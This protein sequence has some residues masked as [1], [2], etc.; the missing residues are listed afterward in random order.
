MT[1]SSAAPSRGEEKARRSTR[2]RHLSLFE[3]AATSAVTLGSME[4][5]VNGRP[6]EAVRGGVTSVRLTSSD[7]GSVR[8]DHYFSRH[9]HGNN[10]VMFW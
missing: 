4:F 2:S 9:E 7:D 10:F 1:P 5:S 8:A 6:S 3:A